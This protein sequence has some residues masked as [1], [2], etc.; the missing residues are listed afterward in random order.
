MLGARLSYG[1][2]PK[3]ERI[4]QR[5][6][7]DELALIETSWAGGQIQNRTS[8]GSILLLVSHLVDTPPFSGASHRIDL[9]QAQI[10]ESVPE[11]PL[12]PKVGSV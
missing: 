8:P 12:W 6:A 5:N 2:A 7:T 1:K 9:H 10:L 3:R 4:N 11:R